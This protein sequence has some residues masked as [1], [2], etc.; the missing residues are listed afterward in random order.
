MGTDVL[1]T[2]LVKYL[3]YFKQYISIF[4]VF[5]TC[6][7][8]YCLYDTHMDPWNVYVCMCLHIQRVPGG[9]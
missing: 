5:L 7:T 3:E 9:M 8:S 2:V 4:R 6:S 1:N